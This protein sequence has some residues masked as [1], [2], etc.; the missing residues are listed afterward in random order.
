MLTVALFGLSAV[1]RADSPDDGKW[2]LLL[3]DNRGGYESSTT[4]AKRGGQNLLYSSIGYTSRDYGIALYASHGDTGYNSPSATEDFRLSSLMDSTLS[5][6]YMTP[7]M[8]AFALRLGLDLNLPTGHPT[9][10]SSQLNAIMVDNVSKE[11]LLMPS[12]GKGLNIAPNLVL[13]GDFGRTQAGL[14]ARY[15]LTGEYNPVSDVP[16]KI[17]D[18]GDMLTL[19]GSL[20]LPV[21]EKDALLFD[22]S[23]VLSTRDKQGGVE[24]FKQGTVYNFTARYL[25]TY[26]MATMVYSLTYGWQDKNQSYAGGAITTEDRNTNNNRWEVLV[27]GTRLLSS[28]YLLNGLVGFKHVYANGYDSTD[29]MYDGGYQK[30]YFG[31][32]PSYAASDKLTFLA[33]IK[34][35]QIWNRADSLEPQSAVYRGLNVNVGFLYSWGA[36]RA[37]GETATPAN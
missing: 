5:S 11:L 6:Y 9:F 1:A 8:G 23:A 25:N 12:F 32:G 37:G 20:Q 36:S 4:P 2:Q 14:G 13:V 27:S 16:N 3:S 15:E 24:V 18:P 29:A 33:D 17:Y 10:T 35:Y 7:K 26:E 31:G 28:S 34:L 22:L 21:A 30:V 19:F